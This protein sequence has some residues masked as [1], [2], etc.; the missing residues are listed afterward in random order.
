MLKRNIPIGSDV[1]AGTF[2]CENC[3]QEI[4]TS[5]TKSLP[6]CPNCQNNGFDNLL[7]SKRGWQSLSGVGDGVNDPHHKH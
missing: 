1:S 4:K 7:P 5:S 6:P 3:G 2:K